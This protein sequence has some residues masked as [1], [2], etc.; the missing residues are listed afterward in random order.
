[1]DKKRL[2]ESSP[3]IKTLRRLLILKL[4]LT[5][6]IGLVY[7]YRNYWLMVLLLIGLGIVVMINSYLEYKWEVSVGG[8][9]QIFRGRFLNRFFAILW[10]LGFFIFTYL[11]LTNQF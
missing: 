7:Y 1:M 4:S 9:N 11:L 2:T 5:F 8:A 6:V 10:P 3:Q